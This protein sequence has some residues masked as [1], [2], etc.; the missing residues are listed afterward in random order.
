MRR[1]QLFEVSDHRW[2]PES[3][4]AIVTDYLQFG[5]KKWRMDAAI[6]SLL[7]RALE[8]AGV[9]QVIDLCSGSGG[10]WLNI[11]RDLES[12]GFPVK[13]LLTDKYPNTRAFKSVHG[14]FGGL[15]EF[16]PESVDAAHVPGSLIG[17]RTIFSAFHHFHPPVARAI[18]QDA[19]NCQQGVAIFEITQRTSWAVF[20]F[21]LM[22]LLVPFCVPFMRPFRWS[23]LAWTYLVPIAP[24]VIFFDSLVSC[25]RTY[26]PDELEQLAKGTGAKGYTWE[27]GE[28]K[29]AHAPVP[30][31]YLLGY[32]D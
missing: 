15:F 30:I 8:N 11:M 24:A 12:A 6:G 27:A 3:I 4:R 19:V 31:T 23:R 2:C 5:V 28:L 25:L 22:S 32:P 9:H 10:P 13:V 29:T 17:F 20:N 16:S 18:L 7:R 26:S 21:F 1:L 14:V